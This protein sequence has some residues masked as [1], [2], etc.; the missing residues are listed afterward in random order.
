MWDDIAVVVDLVRLK[1]DWR[2]GWMSSSGC[3][4]GLVRCQEVQMSRFSLVMA[5]NDI[6]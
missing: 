4:S 1:L 2:V 3:T 5:G 6:P